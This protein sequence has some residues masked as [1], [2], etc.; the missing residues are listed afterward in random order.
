MRRRLV[1]KDQTSSEEGVNGS[2]RKNTNVQT[3][4]L[5]LILE[6]NEAMSGFQPNSKDFERKMAL[7]ETREV[8][9]EAIKVFQSSDDLQLIREVQNIC[10]ERDQLFDAQRVDARTC[11]QGIHPSFKI[12]CS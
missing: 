5:E 10:R 8:L 4:K 9:K 7:A 6:T 12:C 2:K 11:I 3:K 1:A